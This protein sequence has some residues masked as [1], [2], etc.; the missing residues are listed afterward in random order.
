V[1]NDDN[2]SYMGRSA[3]NT[4]MMV[5]FAVPGLNVAEAELERVGQGPLS[6][7]EL[8]QLLRAKLFRWGGA[9]VGVAASIGMFGMDLFDYFNPAQ[10]TAGDM[11]VTQADLQAAL[12]DL[13]SDL[14]D[15]L[16]KARIDD[17][18]D[19]LP[20]LN[21]GFHDLVDSLK[22]L[23]INADRFTLIASDDHLENLVS[24]IYNY[25]NVHDPDGLLTV[26]RGFRNALQLTSSDASK[27]TSLQL[28]EHQTRTIGLYSLVGSLS[29]AYLKAAVMWK[30]GRELLLSY[31][32][33][34]YQADVDFWND[35][36]DAS[37]QP[38]TDYQDNHP[39]E[40]LLEKYDEIVANPLYKSPEWDDWKSQPGCPWQ[41]LLDEVQ[42]LLDYCETVPAA[43]ANPAQDGLYTRMAKSL[44]EMEKHAAD[45]DVTLV[46][47]QGIKIAQMKQAFLAG[48]TR[49]NWIETLETE[50][51]LG[52][53]SEEDID[54]FGQAIGLWR[55]TAAS[56]NYKTYT[57]KKNEMLFDI[58]K[59]QYQDVTFAS[60]LWS[61]NPEVKL[62]NTFY[63]PEGAVLKI[64]TKQALVDLKVPV[65]PQMPPDP[66]FPGT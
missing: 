21:Q 32:Y 66:S 5:G 41:L 38:L 17:I 16:W 27:I 42:S 50:Y 56:V 2:S 64:F 7:A 1:A 43:G 65:P 6:P 47:N 37:G 48:A 61:A 46:P 15:A 63:V 49:A 33:L 60:Q 20:A 62:E 57:A 3:L 30:W 19:E 52:P 34:Q 26:L 23:E 39:F 58:A 13:K 4:A 10:R 36:V 11:E 22:K 12:D 18:S 14:I 55:A 45:G 35:P 53:V 9:A 24:D 8:N 25:F 40:D 51:G 44:D 28:L 31:Q 54:N 29:V 59:S